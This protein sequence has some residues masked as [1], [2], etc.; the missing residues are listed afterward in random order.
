MGLILAAICVTLWAYLLVG[1]GHFWAGSVN[2]AL[3]PPAPQTW[4]SVAI[5]VPARNEAD[6]VVACVGSLLRQNYR[7]Q[8]AVIVVDDD[9]NDGTAACVTYVMESL[10]NGRRAEVL[11]SRGHPPGWTGKLWALQQG[12][13]FTEKSIEADYLLLTDADIVHAPDTLEWLVGHA[14]AGGYVLTSLMAKLRCESIVERIHVPAFIY[15]F[16]ML[17]PFAWVA[18]PNAST[19]AAAGGCMLVRADALRRAG[20]IASVRN[21][22]IDDCSLAA[23]LKTIGPIWLGL[24]NRARS[25][26]RYDTFADARQMITRS[27]YAQLRYSPLLLLGTVAGMALTFIAGPLLAIFS[28]GL[29]QYFG[30]TAWLAMAVS[31]WPTLRFYRMSPLWVLALPLI[32]CLYTF[33][34]LVSAYQHFRRRGGQWKGRVHVNAPR[35]Q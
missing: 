24:T 9:S 10:P 6:D 27:A 11:A 7:G 17:F 18:R 30:A 26:R 19:A 35:L 3:Q 29:P 12:I 14:M 23:R 25:I 16:Q 31:F 32:A 21:A 22:L 28:T 1:R 15:F 5:I 20:G 13:A 34:T 33:Y 4:P 8:V 2:D